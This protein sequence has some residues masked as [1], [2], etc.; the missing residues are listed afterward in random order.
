MQIISALRRKPNILPQNGNGKTKTLPLLTGQT[1]SKHDR[2]SM[3]FSAQSTDFSLESILEMSAL[4]S[5]APRD[6]RPP[7]PSSLPELMR[8]G[9]KQTARL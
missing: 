4:T 3:C 5:V 9:P 7:R 6:P 8:T 1:S 2:S